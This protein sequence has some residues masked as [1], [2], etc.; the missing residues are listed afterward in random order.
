MLIRDGHWDQAADS[1]KTR[2][3]AAG[4]KGTLGVY[5]LFGNVWEWV[6]D[7]WRADYKGAASDTRSNQSGD[8]SR[9]VVRGGGWSSGSAVVRASNRSAAL[10]TTRSRSIGFRVVREME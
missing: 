10:D 5:D 6:D 1:G 4:G 2:P 8:C 9:R 7:C 3:V